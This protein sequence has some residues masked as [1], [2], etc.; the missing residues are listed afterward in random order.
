MSAAGRCG[1]DRTAAVLC[2]AAGFRDGLHANFIAAAK[3]SRDTGDYSRD[4]GDG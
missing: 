4:T 3:Y 1:G 2:A